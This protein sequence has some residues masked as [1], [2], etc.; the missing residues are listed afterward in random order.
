MDH[1]EIARAVV[2]WIHVENSALLNHYEASSGNSLP[3]FRDN[4]SGLI[5]K[6]QKSKKWIHAVHDEAVYVHCNWRSRHHEGE[7]KLLH[8]RAAT[9]V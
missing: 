1:M 9:V 5:F 3:T 4:L 7:Q 2:K 8:R 6:G